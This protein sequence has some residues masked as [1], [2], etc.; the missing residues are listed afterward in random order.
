MQRA[1]TYFQ[2][3]LGKIEKL[4]NKLP[5]VTQETKVSQ[6]N[7]PVSNPYMDIYGSTQSQ[8]K[9]SATRELATQPT[10]PEIIA[11]PLP[12]QPYTPGL[13]GDHMEM[14]SILGSSGVVVNTLKE[15][16]QGGPTTLNSIQPVETVKLPVVEDNSSELRALLK[17]EL[18]GK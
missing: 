16:Y 1:V 15:D 14:P 9:V 10:K 4:L 7:P 13:Q 17:S 2:A 5:M 3:E 12:Y 18:D 11:P 8:S 6:G